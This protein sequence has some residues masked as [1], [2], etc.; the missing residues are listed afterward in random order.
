MKRD[1]Y[2]SPRSVDGREI[3]RSDSRPQGYTT[4]FTSRG[5]SLTTIGNGKEM[6]WDFSDSNDDVTD[7]LTSVIPTG[8]KRKRL[9][10]GFSD[11]IY[12]KEG[13]FYFFNAPKGCR[14]DCWITC[15]TGGYYVDPNGTIPA[16]ALGLE[17]TDMY[18]Q[19][20]VDTPIMRYVNSHPIQGNADIGDELNTEGAAESALPVQQQG[21]QIWLEITTPTSDITSNGCIELEIYRQ[22]TTLLPG[23][24][25]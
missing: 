3:F 16:S 13:T 15:V 18:T 22:R 24:T 10:I 23:E 9:K 21:Y 8:F 14:V 11:Q 7:S 17:S 6:S 4:Y 5:D 20:L 12:L 2:P 1:A 25:L 19:A